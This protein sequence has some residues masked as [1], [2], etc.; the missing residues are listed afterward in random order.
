MTADLIIAAILL[1]S[2]L[3]AMMRGFTLELLSIAAFA[4]AGLIALLLSP[5]VRPLLDHF[6]P[7]PWMTLT[8]T[9]GLVFFVA[10]IPLWY[11]GDTIAQK[12]R[13]SK[14]GVIDR[15]A[16][17]AFGLVR[18]LFVLAIAYLILDGFTGT[19]SG[20]PGWLDDRHALLM[21][22]VRDTGELLLKVAP[23]VARDARKDVRK[24]G[25]AGPGRFTPGVPGIT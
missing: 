19:G 2:G 17:F 18:G 21:P 24:L 23:D 12:V 16:G 14:V 6:F 22:V 15:T 20:R 11:L 1:A 25:N 13:K 3:L 7:A 5:Y 10:L 4:V 8:A 9:L